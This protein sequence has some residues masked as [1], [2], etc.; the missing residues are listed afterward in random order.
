MKNAMITTIDRAGRV[1][2]PK[3]IREEAGLTPGSRLVVRQRD[4][5]VEME[6]EPVPVRMERRGRL[7][8]A[9]PEGD[10]PRLTAEQ[11]RT[12]LEKI[13]RRED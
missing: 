3:R 9:V 2:I 7:L 4:G 6:P 11:V 12:T 10:G 1:V 5:R 13:R 8:V